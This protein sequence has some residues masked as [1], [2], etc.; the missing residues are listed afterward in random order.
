MCTGVTR[1]SVWGPKW[2]QAMRQRTCCPTSLLV[3][4]SW[5]ISICAIAVV[6]HTR[7]GAAAGE[8]RTAMVV[9]AVWWS[10]HTCTQCAAPCMACKQ[11]HF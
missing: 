3:L 8:D 5:S 11:G 10:A 9:A 4:K 2:G 6:V 7:W 1:S